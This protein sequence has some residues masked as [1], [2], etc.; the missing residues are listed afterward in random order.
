M[1]ALIHHL[2]EKQELTPREV[3]V[4]ADLLQD[5]GAP[6]ETRERLLEALS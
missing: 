2:E 5:P 3:E 1:D 6:D 4:A